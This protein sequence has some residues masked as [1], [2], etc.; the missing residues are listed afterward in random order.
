MKLSREDELVLNV[1]PGDYTLEILVENCGRINY[2]KTLEW[3]MQKKGLGPENQLSV[4]GGD[5][6]TGID[7]V[8][9]PLRPSWVSRFVPY[10][11]RKHKQS[12]AIC[13]LTVRNG[14]KVTACNLPFYT[15]NL[16]Y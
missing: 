6:T 12:K 10:N 14:M 1:E 16:H 7:I 4:T 2:V 5:F 9:M 3:L 15:L 8:G 11:Y 13:A